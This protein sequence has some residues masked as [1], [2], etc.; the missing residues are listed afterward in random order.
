[1]IE[2]NEFIASIDTHKILATIPIM[3]Y[4][5]IM[6]MGAEK[7]LFPVLFGKFV[8]DGKVVVF[9]SNKKNIT[10][11]NKI[12]KKINLGNVKLNDL[13]KT[14]KIPKNTI[15]GIFVSDWEVYKNTV[16]SFENSLNKNSWLSILSDIDKSSEY[17]DIYKDLKKDSEIHINEK[18]KLYNYRY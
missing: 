11:T 18:Y 16:K 13:S 17:I 5:T 6:C 10:E 2:S 1:M 8:F 15:D 7:G 4:Q 3:P 12:L 14:I 9:E